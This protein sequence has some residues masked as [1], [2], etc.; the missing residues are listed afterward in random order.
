MTL[1]LVVAV[2]LLGADRPFKIQV[3]DDRTGRGVPLVELRAVDQSTYYTDSAGVVALDEPAFMAVSTY[4]HVKSHGYEYPADGFGF[5]GVKLTP[6][7]GGSSVLKIGRRNIAERL[8]RVTGGG[9][10]RDSVLVGDRVPIREPLL[11]AQVV[12]SDSC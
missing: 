12:G 4:F 7:A 5:R 2:A 1:G 6:T 10:Y 9:I 11:N 3:V 8:Y